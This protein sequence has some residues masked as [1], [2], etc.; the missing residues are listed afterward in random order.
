MGCLLMERTKGSLCRSSSNKSVMA[1]SNGRGGGG[2]VRKWARPFLEVGY[3]G[4]L[5]DASTRDWIGICV[6]RSGM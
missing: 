1:G 3:K 4:I 5:T 6:H 2:N